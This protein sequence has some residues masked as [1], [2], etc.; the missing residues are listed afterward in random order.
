MIPRR[1]TCFAPRPRAM[2]MLVLLAASLLPLTALAADPQADDL[3]ANAMRILHANCLS[4]H[5]AEKHKGG[6]NLLS[7]ESALKG[8]DSGAALTPGEADKSFIVQVV[9]PDSDPHMSPKKQLSAAQSST[10]RDWVAAHQS[11]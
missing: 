4:C 3:A 8:G 1:M 11:R 9:Q 10:L 5:N 2:A 6:L 7:R